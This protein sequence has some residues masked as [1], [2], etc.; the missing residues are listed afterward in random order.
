MH[1]ERLRQMKKKKTNRVNFFNRLYF[2]LEYTVYNKKK[3][4]IPSI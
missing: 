2:L 1:C 4:I 3:N